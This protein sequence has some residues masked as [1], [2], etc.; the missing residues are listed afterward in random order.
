MDCFASLAMTAGA[1]AALAPVGQIKEVF[2]VRAERH[3]FFFRKRTACLG[4]IKR[5]DGS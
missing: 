2:L 3:R 1:L 4:F 5:W